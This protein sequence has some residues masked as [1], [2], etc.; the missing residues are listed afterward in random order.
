MTEEQRKKIEKRSGEACT[1][2]AGG[3]FEPQ[4][5]RCAGFM[6]G[7]EFALK[8][9]EDGE[10]LGNYNVILCSGSVN[11][12]ITCVEFRTKWSRESE[13]SGL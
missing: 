12:D 10:R 3:K 5:L 8:M 13:G 2:A 1:G 7:A 9:V 11:N 4:C 6:E